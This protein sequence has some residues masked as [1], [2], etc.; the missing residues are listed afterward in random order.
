MDLPEPPMIDLPTSTSFRC[1]CCNK[2]IATWVVSAHFICPS[3]SKALISNKKQ[4]FHRGL[5]IGVAVY[6][7]LAVLVQLFGHKAPALG[8]IVYALA[9]VIAYYSGYFSYRASVVITKPK[10]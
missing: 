2:K 3:C 9:A 6:F 4:A 10:G 8:I 1:P 7:S 5:I